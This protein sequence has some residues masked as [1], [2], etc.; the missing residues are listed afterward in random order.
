MTTARRW[1]GFF[2]SLLDGCI[3]NEPDDIADDLKEAQRRKAENIPPGYMDDS[4]AGL[5]F[6]GDYLMWKQILSHGKEKQNSV[7]LVTSESKED[8]WEKKSGKR[9]NPRLE[10]LQEAFEKTEQK[11]LIYHT[12][13]FLKLHQERTGGISDESVLEEI[14][15]Y[16]LAREPAV[17]VS[18]EVDTAGK[19]SNSGRLRITI[20]RPV[21]NF[22]GTGRLEPNLSSPPG[23]TARL[24]ESPDEAPEVRV[25]AK[26]GTTFDFNIHVYSDEQ[27]KMLPVGEYLLVYEA[28]CGA[29][30]EDMGREEAS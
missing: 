22:T 26:T 10:L 16:S 19:S 29:Q 12:D 7:I 18:Q 20:A 15:E 5:G 1:E 2:R 28:S 6:A 14:R 25:R 9:L 17:S 21:R 3:G 27:D 4:K 11:I 13:Q 30:R 24:E 8:W 23:V